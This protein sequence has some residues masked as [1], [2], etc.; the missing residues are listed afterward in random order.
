[1]HRAWMGLGAELQITHLT[2]KT[3]SLSPVIQALCCSSLNVTN[4]ALILSDGHL[5]VVLLDM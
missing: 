5:A 2:F 1:M 3:I 4:G